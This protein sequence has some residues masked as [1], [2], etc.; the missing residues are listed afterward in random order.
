MVVNVTHS[1]VT[2]C[3]PQIVVQGICDSTSKVY[4]DGRVDSGFVA[5]GCGVCTKLGT[6]ALAQD[7][8]AV[9]NARSATVCSADAANVCDLNTFLG[10]T[11]ICVQLANQSYTNKFCAQNGSKS[12]SGLD[13]SKKRLLLFE[14]S[15]PDKTKVYSN[16][17]KFWYQQGGA[18][19]SGNGKRSAYDAVVFRRV[20]FV[21][22]FASGAVSTAT[23][24]FPHARTMREH[25]TSLGLNALS[26]NTNTRVWSKGHARVAW[27]AYG[28]GFDP[29]GLRIGLGDGS[30]D[31]RDWALFMLQA[32]NNIQDFLGK[33][34]LNLGGE[35][36]ACNAK[37]VTKIQMFAED[38]SGLPSE[39]VC[40]KEGGT[41]SC[42][43]GA[44]KYGMG[45]RFTGYKSVSSSIGCTNSVWGDPWPGMDKQCICTPALECALCARLKA[46]TSTFWSVYVRTIG[47]LVAAADVA[48]FL[49]ALSLALFGGPFARLHLRDRCAGLAA[50][51]LLTAAP[52]ATVIVL[53]RSVDTCSPLGSKEAIGQA[54]ST[55][56]SRL[57]WAAVTQLLLTS[58]VRA[59]FRTGQI[60]QSNG[61][62]ALLLVEARC[63]FDILPCFVF[64][65][66]MHLHALGTAS[67]PVF[68]II[69][70]SLLY[71]LELVSLLP[72]ATD[73]LVRSATWK[74]RSA[75]ECDAE[76]EAAAERADQATYTEILPA[77]CAAHQ[78]LVLAT[79]IVHQRRLFDELPLD[80]VDRVLACLASGF[81]DGQTCD[82]WEVQWRA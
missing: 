30:A 79:G 19:R 24:V 31:A 9:H 70:M 49:S 68:S 80:V 50:L 48:A 32:G 58:L 62:R 27:T 81:Q 16:S 78:R 13:A 73:C 34:V 12:G 52:L 20:S 1:G 28:P 37:N 59:G 7:H 46:S 36:L 66:L 4:C 41:C 69:I 25:V 57:V 38:A 54:H 47:V 75:T 15:S 65:M 14:V 21:V 44:V 40:A 42:P 82:R 60:E 51:G 55:L 3:T 74:C 33:S 77:L 35:T 43:G 45:S 18:T 61:R 71:L 22:T 72:L 29:A 67:L 64:A 23:A 76:A 10:T 5:D 8:T 53:Q 56:A 26:S 2:S 11:E 17:W 6:T 39:S 63:T